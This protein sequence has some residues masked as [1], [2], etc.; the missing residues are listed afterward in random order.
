MCLL[1]VGPLDLP[2]KLT[3]SDSLLKVF[4]RCLQHVLP[5]NSLVSVFLVLHLDDLD[6]F[7]MHAETLATCLRFEIVSNTNIKFLGPSGVATVSFDYVLQVYA[8]VG[9]LKSL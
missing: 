8:L 2:F 3:F 5:L 4:V 9:A 6:G 7:W 1:F